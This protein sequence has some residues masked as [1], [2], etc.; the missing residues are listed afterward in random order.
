MVTDASGNG[1]YWG[2]RL[3]M[4]L[5]SKRIIIYIY[6]LNCIYNRENHPIFL[7]KLFLSNAN[8]VCFDMFEMAKSLAFPGCHMALSGG[9]QWDGP[10]DLLQG[11]EG[12]TIQE[13]KTN[14]K[15][16]GNGVWGNHGKVI[17][18]TRNCPLIPLPSCGFRSRIVHE[19]PVSISYHFPWLSTSKPIFSYVPSLS[20]IHDYP[21][22]IFKNY[23]QWWIEGAIQSF[24]RLFS[25]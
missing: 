9:P 23:S 12:F 20:I 24:F 15:S 16:P 17:Y 21:T 22:S 18:K 3:E 7:W 10:W 2:N 19:Y 8:M 25:Y 5:W 6:K 1:F 4:N 11:T 13:S 14:G